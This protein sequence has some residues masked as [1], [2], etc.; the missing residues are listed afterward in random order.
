MYMAFS[1]VWQN[2]RYLLCT[3]LDWGKSALLWGVFTLPILA[4]FMEC[5][6]ILAWFLC[7]MHN[8]PFSSKK[9]SLDFN[10]LL[11]CRH[12]IDL[13]DFWP[14]W[15]NL[16]LKVYSLVPICYRCRCCQVHYKKDFC[17]TFAAYILKRIRGW[18]ICSKNPPSNRR[19]IYWVN[20][21]SPPPLKTLDS[22]MVK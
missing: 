4:H 13:F 3:F 22:E 6:W 12:N 10:F 15:A 21:K 18:Q 2:N 20:E 17:M 19:S 8:N 9:K 11:S 1:L 14:L 16:V 5:V 7:E